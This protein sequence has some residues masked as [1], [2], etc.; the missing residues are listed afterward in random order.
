MPKKTKKFTRDKKSKIDS[1]ISA[2]IEL[3]EEKGYSGFTVDDIPLRA[4]L[5]IGTVYRYFPNGKPD[6]LR[7]IVKRNDRALNGMIEF[8]KISEGKFYDF[9]RS[10]IRAYLRGHREGLFSLTA[11]QYSFGAEPQFK[12]VIGPIITGFFQKLVNQ[13]KGLKK[14]ANLS[15]KDLFQ[16]VLLVFGFISLL[17]KSHVSRPFFA[18]D[19]KLV[20]YLDKVSR[21]TFEM[22]L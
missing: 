15:E 5:S 13:I 8:E 2:T 18:S 10:V 3:I 16:R 12:E 20:E 7:E 4:N 9:W 11:M 19:E 22:E 14:F 17:V 1:I 6:I 21:L